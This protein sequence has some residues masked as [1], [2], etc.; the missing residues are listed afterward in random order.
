MSSLLDKHLFYH[1]SL[2]AENSKWEW[3]CTRRTGTNRVP[4]QKKKKNIFIHSTRICLGKCKMD[5]EQLESSSIDENSRDAI[6]INR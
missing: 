5:G 2:F 4:V 1:S 6:M 3:E